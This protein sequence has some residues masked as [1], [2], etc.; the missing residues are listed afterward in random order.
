[1][2]RFALASC[3]FLR[4]FFRLLFRGFRLV[5]GAVFRLFW[6]E[7]FRFPL[8]P[9]PDFR[10]LEFGRPDELFR[11]LEQVFRRDAVSSEVRRFRKPPQ[12]FRKSSAAR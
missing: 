10:L 11:L 4:E 6:E 1:M 12:R 9:E 3:F 8:W 7:L 2:A 5:F